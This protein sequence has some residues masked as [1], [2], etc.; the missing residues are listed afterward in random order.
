MNFNLPIP[1]QNDSWITPPYIISVI[2]LSELDPFGYKHPDKGVLVKTAQNYFF[3]E[4]DGLSKDWNYKSVFVNFPYSKAKECMDKVT[5]QYKKYNNNIIVLCFNRSETRWYQN[6]VRFSTGINM[7][8]RR[9]K[10]YD[11]EGNLRSNGN[12]PSCL[13]AFGEDAYSRIKNVEGICC[14]IDK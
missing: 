11:F 3:E 8:K 10:F 6:N 4:D 2:G 12:A 13:I 5:E 7:I 14:R 9:I 1:N